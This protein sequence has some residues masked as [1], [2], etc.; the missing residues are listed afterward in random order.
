VNFIK[1][2]PK[3]TTEDFSEVLDSIEVVFGII[4]RKIDNS[5]AGDEGAKKKNRL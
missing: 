4:K 3:T 5:R 2:P 1:S